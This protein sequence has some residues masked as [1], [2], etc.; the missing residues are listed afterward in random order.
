MTEQATFDVPEK[1]P[2]KD[3]DTLQGLYHGDDLNQ[4]EIA[5][6]FR[7]EGH[8]VSASNISYWMSKFEI[9]TTHSDYEEGRETD[10]T[11][12]K[13]VRDE[14]EDEPPGPNRIC[15]S[16]LDEVREKQRIAQMEAREQEARRS[17]EWGNYQ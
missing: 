7:D 17:E 16:C 1:E 15:D 11:V 12:E 8:E 14:C 2:W 4:S 10:E 6:Y 3:K 5:A 9:E 13:C